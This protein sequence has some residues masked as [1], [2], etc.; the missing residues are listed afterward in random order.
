MLEQVKVQMN[1]QISDIVEIISVVFKREK[2]K[3]TRIDQQKEE[4]IVELFR[5]QLFQSRLL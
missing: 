1:V 2:A 5:K 4:I 3:V